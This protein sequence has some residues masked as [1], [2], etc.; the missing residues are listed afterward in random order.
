MT[1]PNGLDTCEL[2]HEPIGEDGLCGCGR[3]DEQHAPRDV[4]PYD[5]REDR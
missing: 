5:S 2:C 4:D 3:E 1:D